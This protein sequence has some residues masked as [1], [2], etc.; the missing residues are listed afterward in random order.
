MVGRP[1]QDPVADAARR[2][3]LAGAPIAACPYP[4]GTA[5]SDRWRAVFRETV[6]AHGPAIAAALHRARG[7]EDEPLRRPYAPDEEALFAAMMAAGKDAAQIAAALGRSVKAIKIKMTLILQGKESWSP[8]EDAVL[9]RLVADP[10]RLTAFA[11]GVRLQRTENAVN[12]RC[13]RLGIKLG[14]RGGPRP[15][16]RPAESRVAAE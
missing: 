11:I 13:C 2:A 14:R 16:T 3:A 5:F 10:A 1:F 4:E 15:E 12:A 6:Q 7:A 8:S 9:R